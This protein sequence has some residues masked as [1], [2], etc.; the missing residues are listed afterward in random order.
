MTK[1]LRVRKVQKVQKEYILKIALKTILY[2]SVIM[3][4]EEFIT[5]LQSVISKIS[6]SQQ[7]SLTTTKTN[8][9]EKQ[10]H[11]NLTLNLT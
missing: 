2:N 11:D 9:N 10:Q 8:D 5:S 1:Q 4:R 7:N 6:M 3:R